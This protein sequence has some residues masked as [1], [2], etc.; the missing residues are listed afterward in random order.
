MTRQ[1]TRL[2]LAG[3]LAR[4]LLFQRNCGVCG[5]PLLANREAWY[6]LCAGC[7]EALELDDEARCRSCGKPLIS[8][9]EQ[10]L[11]CRETEEHSLNLAFSVYPYSGPCQKLLASFKFEKNRAV[12]NFLAEKLIEA[13]AL[14]GF[15]GEDRA[16]LWVPVPPRPHKLRRTGWDQVT[17]LARLLKKT[18]L[19]VYPCLKRLPSQTQKQLDRNSRMTNLKGRIVCTRQPPEELILFDDVIT[20]GA[21]LNACAGALKEGG[22]RRVMAITLFYG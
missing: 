4:E 5:A 17:C 1:I 21:T 6:G 16:P 3:A 9:R 20:T 11:P 13:A 10:C 8:E 7:M 2:N 12:G 22:A 18:G 19:P 14:A 15:T